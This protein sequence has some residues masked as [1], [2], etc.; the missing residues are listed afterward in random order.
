M[1]KRR[2]LSSILCLGIAGP[3]AVL[4]WK[5]DSPEIAHTSV[6]NAAFDNSWMI[7][8]LRLVAMVAALYVVTSIV[9]RVS[10][11]Q[12]VKQLG[13]VST[14]APVQQVADDR[15]QLQE[16]LAEANQTVDDLTRRVAESDATVDRLT[17]MKAPPRKSRP[18]DRR[19]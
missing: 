17:N 5:T 12:W 2:W 15:R 14:D 19:R 3:G 1:T 7:A 6:L 8:A 18:W 16:E 13:P 9:A 4:I 11:G 10:R